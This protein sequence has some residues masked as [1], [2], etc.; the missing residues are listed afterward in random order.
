MTN[1]WANQMFTNPENAHKRVTPGSK[2][3]EKWELFKEN[4]ADTIQALEDRKFMEA[5][6]V[7]YVYEDGNR[8]KGTLAFFFGYAADEN[9]QAIHAFP[10]RF[11]QAGEFYFFTEEDAETLAEDMNR[12]LASEDTLNALKEDLHTVWA[13]KVAAGAK[14]RARAMDSVNAALKEAREKYEE[15]HRL[16][17]EVT[18][19]A[20]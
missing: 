16:S 19:I 9:T 3:D 13:A 6:F 7:R 10:N 20:A 15:A 1:T 4:L 8:K 5:P 14:G 11:L 12:I 2:F 17:Q 18:A